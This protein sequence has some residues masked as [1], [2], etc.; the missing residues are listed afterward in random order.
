MRRVMPMRLYSAKRSRATTWISHL[1]CVRRAKSAAVMPAMP[2]PTITMRLID[3]SQCTT[4]GGAAADA[5]A[6]GHARVGRV[7]EPPER[8]LLV[9]P[10]RREVVQPFDH[11]DRVGPADAHA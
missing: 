7:A 8:R 10:R 6:A 11:R 5:R 2:L 3:S 9:V 4:A 1:G